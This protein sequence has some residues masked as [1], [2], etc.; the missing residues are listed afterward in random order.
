MLEETLE[1][2]AYD[3]AA[4]ETE[5]MHARRLLQKLKSVNID[6]MKK[7]IKKRVSSSVVDKWQLFA[8]ISRWIDGLPVVFGHD[9]DWFVYGWPEYVEA[10]CSLIEQDEVELDESMTDKQKIA[11]HD[12]SF[13]NLFSN[14]LVLSSVDVS[15]QL[16]SSYGDYDDIAPVISKIGRRDTRKA[17]KRWSSVHDFT[18]PEE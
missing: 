12:L 5:R 3:E 10:V 7:C 16:K 1:L 8:R 2:L 13:K 15:S 18:N 14:G 6:D 4:S 9:E 17:E 11:Y